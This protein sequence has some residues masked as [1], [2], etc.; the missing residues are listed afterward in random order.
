MC[1]RVCVCVCI[2]VCVYVCACA[3]ARVCVCVCLCVRVCVCVRLVRERLWARR[4]MRLKGVVS[5]AELSDSPASA[6][7]SAAAG[8]MD[9]ADVSALI[10][11]GGESSSGVCALNYGFVYMYECMHSLVDV[12]MHV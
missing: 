3:C 4:F 9:D 1:A 12:C 8:E 10:S 5:F 2:C 7:L 6:E 11:K